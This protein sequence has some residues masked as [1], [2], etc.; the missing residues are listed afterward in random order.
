VLTF[1]RHRPLHLIALAA[2]SA[3][4]V[5]SAAACGGSSVSSSPAGVVTSLFSDI[6]ANDCNAAYAQLS[7]R[8]QTQ[9]EGKAGVC[10]VVSQLSRRY[11]N[12]KFHIDS[13]ET[14]GNQARVKATRTN[15][16]GTSISTALDTVVDKNAWR[17]D[18]LG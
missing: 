11:Q 17:V 7:T 3:A 18:G 14:H 2:A 12:N 1:R 4:L 5:G 6:E 16:N 8:L 15:P 9:L 10:P 13:V